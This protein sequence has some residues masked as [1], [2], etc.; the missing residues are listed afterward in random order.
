MCSTKIGQLKN[1]IESLRIKHRLCHIALSWTR[2]LREQ[3]KRPITSSTDQS[4]SDTSLIFS[5]RSVATTITEWIATKNWKM[6]WRRKTQFLS[7][8]AFSVELRLS[9]LPR[10][11]QRIP[12]SITRT[13]LWRHSRAKCLF[14]ESISRVQT[15]TQTHS[16]AVQV[17][18]QHN[19]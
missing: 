19:L 6:T 16:W 9:W 15:S 8:S 5:C 1:E 11:T 3:P 18:S 12:L 7:S 14:L 10:L 17:H 13:P 4:A 2:H